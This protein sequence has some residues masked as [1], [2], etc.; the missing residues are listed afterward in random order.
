VNER[1]RRGLFQF[2]VTDGGIVNLYDDVFTDADLPLYSHLVPET[3]RR[4]PELARYQRWRTWQMSDHSPLWVEIATD[5]SNDYLHQHRA[6]TGTRAGVRDLLAPTVRLSVR[7][8]IAAGQ[9]SN[10]ARRRARRHR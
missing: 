4:S 9:R 5:F 2:K 7:P 1:K 8:T 10:R 3:P 6:I